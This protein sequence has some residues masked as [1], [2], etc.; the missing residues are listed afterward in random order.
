[1]TE[2]ESP[3]EREPPGLIDRSV[4]ALMRRVPPAFFRLA[5]A[6]VDPGT[7]QIGDV[8]INLP[9][10]RADQVFLVGEVSDPER[11]AAHLEYQLQPDP[12]VLRGWFLKNAALTAQWDLPVLLTVVYL[13]KGLY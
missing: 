10:F 1:M 13:T 6:D 7:I 4:K 8:S 3:E 5:G 11:W 2:R 9:E 12:R